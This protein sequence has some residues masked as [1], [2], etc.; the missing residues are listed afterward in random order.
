MLM[1]KR[2]RPGRPHDVEDMARRLT[3]R[4]HSAEEIC[5]IYDVSQRT[6]YLWLGRLK[7]Q[8]YDVVHR[9]LHGGRAAWEI[10][11]VPDP[12]KSSE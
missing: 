6:A 11:D 10:L 12:Y 5:R 9:R 2:G 3:E 4:P 7:T 8:G 1:A